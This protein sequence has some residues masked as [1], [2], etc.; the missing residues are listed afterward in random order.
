[1]AL[2]SVVLLREPIR[3]ADVWALG[4]YA[5]GLAL[6][7]RGSLTPLASA[8]DPRIGNLA[9]LASGVTWSFVITG[10]RWLATRLP[11]AATA[12]PILGNALLGVALLPWI[13]HAPIEPGD[14]VVLGWLGVFQVALAYAL[15]ARAIRRVRAFEASLLF[16]A[17]PVLS[18]LW[19]WLAFGERPAAIGIAG[20]AVM[21]AAAVLS[22][23]ASEEPA[24]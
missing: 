24:T 5:V 22:I 9:A 11:D 15:L 18:A 21:L 4:A 7:V 13:A 17:E 12:A 14:A 6:L 10:L 19:A 8:P 1:V 20:C 3:R 2:L 16:L 23:R